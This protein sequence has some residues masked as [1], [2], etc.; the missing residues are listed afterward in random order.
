MDVIRVC[1]K[2]EMKLWKDRPEA[3]PVRWFRADPKAKIFDK[4][5]SFRSN[6]TWQ[7]FEEQFSASMGELSRDYTYDKGANPLKYKGDKHCGRDLAMQFGGVSGV[8]PEIHTDSSGLSPCCGIP[9]PIFACILSGTEH[10]ELILPD[11]L[12]LRLI[13]QAGS[14]VDWDGMTWELQRQE[15]VGF[16]MDN[17]PNDTHY[18]PETICT[19]WWTTGFFLSATYPDGRTDWAGW[20]LGLYNAG[21][22]RPP[23]CV[24]EC[25]V[26]HLWYRTFTLNAGGS[27]IFQQTWSTVAMTIKTVTAEPFNLTMWSHGPNVDAITVFC[28]FSQGMWTVD[29][30]TLFE[31]TAPDI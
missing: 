21:D 5:C 6:F 19:I 25:T 18:E 1:Y 29:Q 13:S 30:A 17:D 27:I 28:V 31:F 11:V 15:G 3:I 8:D 23:E 10:V 26:P 20:G 7:K 14:C 16:F 4:M 9:P 22:D 24:A 2:T 12:Q